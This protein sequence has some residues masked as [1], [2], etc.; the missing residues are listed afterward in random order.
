MKVVIAGAGAVGTFLAT[1][2]ARSAA[3]AAQPVSH[4]RDGD[5]GEK[6]EQRAG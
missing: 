3:F 1:D 4:E 5:T 2:L 6:D